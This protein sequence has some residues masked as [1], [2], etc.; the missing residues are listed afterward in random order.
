MSFGLCL[1]GGGVKGAAH[2]GVL[3]A[4][5][6]ENITIDYIGGTSSGSIV[7]TLFACGYNSDEIYKIFKQYCK[8]IKYIDFK[9]IFKLVL[10]LIFARRIII[11][12]LNSGVQIQKLI[13]KVCNKKG[14]YNI[15]DISVPLAI[16]S[17]DMYDGKVLCFTSCSQKRNFSDDVVFVDDISVGKAVQ[18][19]CS[20]PVVFSPSRYND[21][22]LLD[23]G[24]RENVPWKELKKL[25]ANNILSVTFEESSISPCCKNLIEVAERSLNLLCRELSNYELQGADYIMKIKTQKINLLDMKKIDVLYNL[26]YET[27][28]NNMKIIRQRLDI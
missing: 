14:I 19:S 24:M 5:E 9:N 4:L 3:K 17:V 1:A 11:D 8:K 28:K 26:G 2:I 13:D 10:G 25:G 22:M 6:E 15:S 20:Y 12:G 21:T 23:G 16:P 18:S 7:A 27:A